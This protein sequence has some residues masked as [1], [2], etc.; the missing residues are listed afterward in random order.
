MRYATEGQPVPSESPI[1][2]THTATH[3]NLAASDTVIQTLFGTECLV[4]CDNFKAQF[5]VDGWQNIWKI[6]MGTE[7]LY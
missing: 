7:K 4:C 3:K 2:I 1:I 6:H 5:G